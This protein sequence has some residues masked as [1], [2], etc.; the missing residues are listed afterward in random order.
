MAASFGIGHRCGYA[1]DVALKRKD[2]K[3]KKRTSLIIKQA[4]RVCVRRPKLRVHSTFGHIPLT[5][6]ELGK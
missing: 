4:H 1:A 3:E 2:K 5:H 6:Q